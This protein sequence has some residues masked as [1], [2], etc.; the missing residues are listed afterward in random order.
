MRPLPLIVLLFAFLISCQTKKP[1]T[2]P[3]QTITIDLTESVESQG[4]AEDWIEDI[5]FIRLETNPDYFISSTYRS[6]LNRDHIVVASDGAVH[7]FDR[8]GKL[9]S[10]IEKKS[11]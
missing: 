6:N 1:N 8:N 3:D 9:G 2:G 10:V 4:P 7:L 11:D 5:E